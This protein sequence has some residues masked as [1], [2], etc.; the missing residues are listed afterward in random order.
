VSQLNREERAESEARRSRYG[1]PR[2]NPQK[3]PVLRICPPGATFC[4][5]RFTPRRGKP[6]RFPLFV[7][8]RRILLWCIVNS[9][10][11]A[12]TLHLSGR[13]TPPWH[14]PRNYFSAAHAPASS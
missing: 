1:D 6:P 9:P 3:L 5:K 10:H 8:E 7:R 13:A 12:S 14:D 2:R 11:A 4:F